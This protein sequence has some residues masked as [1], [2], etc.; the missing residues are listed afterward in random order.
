MS[1]QTP[2][3][4]YVNSGLLFPRG[5]EKTEDWHDDYK[6]DAKIVCPCCGEEVDYWVGL[7]KREGRNSPFLQL[8]YRAKENKKKKP[9]AKSN[10]FDEDI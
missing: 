3:R 6:G 8:R 4:K 5:G 1:E 2:D 9:E 10:I 7:R